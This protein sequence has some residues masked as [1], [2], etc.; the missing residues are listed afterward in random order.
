MASELMK[1]ILG[2]PDYEFK[3]ISTDYLLKHRSKMNTEKYWR[4]LRK[5]SVFYNAMI[6]MQKKKGSSV[7]QF[8]TNGLRLIKSEIEKI[9]KMTVQKIPQGSAVKKKSSAKKICMIFMIVILI[10]LGLL[11]LNYYGSI[12]D[13]QSRT[14]ADE[15]ILAIV[16]SWDHKELVSHANPDLLNAFSG[17]DL[18]S[19]FKIYSNN[20]GELKKYEGSNGQTH[21]DVE[22]FCKEGMMCT[23]ITAE[24]IAKA[25]FEKGEA[26]ITIKMVHRKFEWNI[27]NFTV[28]SEQLLRIEENTNN[29]YLHDSSDAKK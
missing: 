14:Y 13:R 4:W 17:D 20:L 11:S 23:A 25:V 29:L 27:Y 16:S 7:P 10:I 21:I 6:I 26:T 8:W 2:G 28:S 22:I 5:K 15:A 24:Y 12:L 19:L 9:E 1:K 3:K 18:I